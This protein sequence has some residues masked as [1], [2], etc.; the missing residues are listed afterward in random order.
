MASNS[1]GN[2][3]YVLIHKS[4]QQSLLFVATWIYR[5]AFQSLVSPLLLLISQDLHKFSSF[6][7]IRLAESWLLLTDKER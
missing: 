1:R 4:Q 5:E 3:D 7:K 6:E 2:S